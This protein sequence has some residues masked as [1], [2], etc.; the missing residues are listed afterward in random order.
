M[1]KSEDACRWHFLTRWTPRTHPHWHLL[2]SGLVWSGVGIMLV[3]LA[4]EWLGLPADRQGLWLF[5]AGLALAWAISR[6]GFS[7]IARKNVR[8]IQRMKDQVCIFA[9]QE[10]KSYLIVVFM[11]T[12][13]STLRHSG[14]P[15]QLLAPL[16][17]GIG[18]GLFLASLA[19]YGQLRRNLL[20]PGSR[21]SE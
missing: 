13:G 19:Y 5:V 7:R 20:S 21:T 14:F 17:T 6:F 18:G 3:N 9:F 1:A 15:R 8:R 4:R 11:M 12:L 16:Y 2:L 10:W